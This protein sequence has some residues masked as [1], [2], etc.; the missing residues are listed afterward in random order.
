[1]KI[2]KFGWSETPAK[3]WLPMHVYEQREHD[4]QYPVAVIRLPVFL[5]FRI[6]RKLETWF[7]DIGTLPV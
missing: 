5:P 2:V 3:P 6:R 1:M 7:A 4:D